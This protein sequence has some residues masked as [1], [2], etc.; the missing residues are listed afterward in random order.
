MI[1]YCLHNVDAAT[2]ARLRS[3][4]CRTVERECLQRCGTC[5]AGPFL[6][7]DGEQH[8]G[9]SHADLVAGAEGE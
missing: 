2:R 7:V 8:R 1:E 6:V 5:W 3:L 4:E 9:D